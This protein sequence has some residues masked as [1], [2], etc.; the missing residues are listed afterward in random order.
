MFENPFSF[1]GRIRRLEYGISSLITMVV[2][3]LV[4]LLANLGAGA[5]I[6]SLFLLIPVLWFSLAQSVKR[7]H[8][9]GNSG[10]F[11]LIPFYGWIL[12]FGGSDYGI[13]GY[14]PN[15]KGEGNLEDEIDQIGTNR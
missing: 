4:S 2:A 8:D 6:I 7:C 9:R 13:N 14:G 11:I 1:Q 5:A 15:P 3:F 12:L 10:W